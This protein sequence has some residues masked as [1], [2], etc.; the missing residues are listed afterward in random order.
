M[1]IAIFFV[2]SKLEKKPGYRT[3]TGFF[4]DSTL[5]GLQTIQIHGHTTW[6]G[7][8]VPTHGSIK[9]D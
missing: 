1:V 6:H 5:N 7:H 8:G 3:A 4:Y 2:F 9:V